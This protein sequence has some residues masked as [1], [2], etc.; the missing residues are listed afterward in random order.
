MKRIFTIFFRDL[1]VNMRDF[2]S[3][4]IYLFPIIFSIVINLISP[5]VNEISV[6]FVFLENENSEMVRYFEDYAGVEKVKTKEDLIERVNKRDDIFGIVS[7]E[8]GSYILA[9]GNEQ[10]GTVEFARIL[11]TYYE[12]GVDI[13]DSNAEIIDF[14]KTVSPMKKMFVNIAILLNTVLGGMIIGL[15]IVEEK[16]DNTISAINITPVSKFEFILGKSMIGLIM[17]IFGSIVILLMT[18]YTD[19][20][21]GQVILTVIAS[22]FISMLIGF[23]QGLTSDDVMSAAAGI[24]VL[25]LPMIAGVAAK[26]FLS[27]AWQRLFYWVPFYWTYTANDEILS[28]TSTWMNIFI[29]SMI[30]IGISVIVYFILAPKI[31]KRLE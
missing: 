3:I 21:F 16:S 31:R 5:S 26:E 8:E 25:F 1:K 22:S 23:I 4:Y 30:V 14:G 11:K 29:Y 19:I 15:N 7:D 12:M 10:K 27:E 20:N 28:Y 24:K 2:L 18:G 17:P 9:Q 6:N 13:E